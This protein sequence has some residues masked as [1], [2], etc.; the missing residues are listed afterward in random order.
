MIKMVDIR[1]IAAEALLGAG[2]V[3]LLREFYNKGIG[4]SLFQTGA[5]IQ[6]VST[7]IGTGIGSIGTG[8]GT[9]FNQLG[10]GF[11]SL[12]SPVNS[13][14]DLV[15]APSG[16]K[17]IQPAQGQTVQQENEIKEALAAIPTP[18]PDNTTQPT[19]NKFLQPEYTWY[20]IEEAQRSGSSMEQAVESELFLQRN[21]AAAQF[22][23][24]Y[25]EYINEM[26]KLGNF[27]W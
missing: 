6:S 1:K 8:I 5:G 27:G 19:V 24:S 26:K 10:S 11:S 22:G 2:A 14:L 20:R 21:V 23:L 3:L 4:P 15:F 7:G 16:G 25:D 12:L 18:I 17:S 13:I 9:A